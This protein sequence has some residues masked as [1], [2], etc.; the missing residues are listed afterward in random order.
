M[1]CIFCKIAEK[2]E[3]SYIVY[4]DEELMVILDKYPMSKGHLLV[5]PKKHYE[6]LHDAPDHIVCKTF[7][8]ASRIAKIYRNHIGSPGVNILSNSGKVAGQIIFH[9]HVHVIP[10]WKKISSDP[11]KSRHVLSSDEAHNVIT[12]ISPYNEKIKQQPNAYC[13]NKNQ[14]TD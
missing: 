8:V 7:M 12:I 9:F 5:I 11:W 1:S 6:S 10:R 3:Q 4:E 2:K 14:E 13:E